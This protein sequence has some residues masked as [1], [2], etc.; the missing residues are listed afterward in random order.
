MRIRPVEAGDERVWATMRARL[1]PG[2]DLTDLTE[3]TRAYVKAGRCATVDAAFVAI[4]DD[5]TVAF[6]ELY[7]RE[8]SDGC[9][10]MPVPHVEGWYVEPEYR[11]RGIG[12]ALI[13]EAR[14]WSRERG[15]SE[16]A[17]DA[18]LEAERSIRAH[19]SCGFE[20]VDRIVKFRTPL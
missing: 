19:I 12:R 3:E 2:A 8:F 1:W 11:G 16:L 6:L 18:E 20:E 5:Q 13:D 17:S 9:D 7:V 14:R 4:V 15:F 10:S